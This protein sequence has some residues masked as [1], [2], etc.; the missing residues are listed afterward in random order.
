MDMIGNKRF[1]RLNRNSDW[2]RIHL[3]RIIQRMKNSYTGSFFN[4]PAFLVFIS[5][6]NSSQLRGWFF[7]CR[8][9]NTVSSIVSSPF[10]KPLISCTKLKNYRFALLKLFFLWRRFWLRLN[11]LMNESFK[12]DTFF[13]KW[14]EL[15]NEH[16]PDVF[17]Q[18]LPSFSKLEWKREHV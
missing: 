18:W 7:S 10:K 6:P 11:Y 2:L 9:F 15:W 12:Q 8:M 3:Q 14:K 16:I 5:G 1:Y 4:T 17:S 13:D